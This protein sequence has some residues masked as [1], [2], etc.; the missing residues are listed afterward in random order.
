MNRFIKRY[1][2][3]FHR[4]VSSLFPFIFNFYTLNAF[5]RAQLC[6]LAFIYTIYL[7]TFWRPGMT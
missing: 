3:N 2:T 4:I 1:K 7:C 5:P 6:M